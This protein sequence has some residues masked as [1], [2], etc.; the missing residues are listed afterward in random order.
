M[1]W[2]FNNLTGLVTSLCT[3]DTSSTSASLA[4]DTT[5]IANLSGC[6]SATAQLLSGYIR[7]A[8][9]DPTVTETESP[10]GGTL[11][12]SIVLTL[13]SS[14]HP[15]TATSCF[16]DSTDDATT[17]AGRREVVYNCLIFSNTDRTWVDLLHIAPMR[18]LSSSVWTSSRTVPSTT[19]CAAT[20]RC[21]PTPERAT[22]I[23]RWTTPRESDLAQA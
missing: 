12:L 4:A 18:L 2:I 3:V 19:R 11:N 1:A 8:A 7:F 21:R 5:F 13:T 16:D 15:T 14:G 6:T 20:H 9:G 17:A 23:I 22:S 10:N